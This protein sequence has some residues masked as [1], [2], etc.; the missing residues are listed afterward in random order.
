MTLYTVDHANRA[1]PLVRRIVEDIVADNRRRHEA[2]VELDLLAAS[3]TAALPDPRMAAL[4]RSIRQLSRDIERWQGELDQLSI[5]LK[6]RAQG[7]IDFPS[8]MDG[9]PMLLCWRL[10]ETSVQYWHEVD[11]GFAGRQPLSIS[12]P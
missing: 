1:L 9:R 10:G 11:A 4:E 8:E 12:F 3:A 6:D 7:L 2:I 5:Q